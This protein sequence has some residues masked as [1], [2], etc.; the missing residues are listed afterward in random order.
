[1][2][3]ACACGGA[4]AH[5]GKACSCA[6]VQAAHEVPAS[7][8][9]AALAEPALDVCERFE[10]WE[11][12]DESTPLWKHAAAGSCAGIMEH[13]GMY[14][15]DTV[16]T[17][18]QAL[19]PGRPVA[20][21]D[22]VRSIMASESGGLGF[23]RG[24]SAIATAAVPA[25][26]AL[27][28]SFEF[29][30][31]TLLTDDDGHEPFRAAI[32]GASATLC[33]D[34]ILTPMD[35]VKQRMQLGCYSNVGDC[36]R[37]VLRQEGIVGLYRSMPT[38]VAMNLPFGS[39]MVATNE[40]IKTSL[41][42]RRCS[43]PEENRAMLP[44]YFF[45]AGVSGAVAS[46]LTQPLDVVKTRLQTQDLLFTRPSSSSAGGSSSSG[47]PLAPKYSGLLPAISMIIRE[48]GWMALYNGLLPRLLHAVPS[49]ALCWGTYEVV[50]SLLEPVR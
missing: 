40:S 8:G 41:R 23:M 47:S 50:K 21:S 38:T 11:E 37:S 42:I 28:T 6:A 45:S 18:M 26:I 15:L 24:C 1:M 39:V 4:G 43:R 3:G 14:P 31:Q 35:L 9:A 49:A 12:W 10:Q 17:H 36:V 29:A 13:L 7:L 20:F 30:K 19:R 27:F 22:V 2:L 16:K 33:H 46:A 32:C 48:E 34:V 25:H 44:W 5:P